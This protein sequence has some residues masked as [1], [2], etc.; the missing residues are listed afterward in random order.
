[1]EVITMFRVK[2]YYK[3]SLCIFVFMCL[4]ASTAYSDIITYTIYER[5]IKKS[6][7][8]IISQLGDK[9]EYLELSADGYVIKNSI[10]PNSNNNISHFKV[11]RSSEEEKQEILKAWGQHSSM[12]TVERRF[13]PALQLV[14][15][16]TRYPLPE[17]VTYVMGKPD[18]KMIP[19][20][21]A[22]EDSESAIRVDFAEIQS[23]EFINPAYAARIIWKN[24]ESAEGTLLSGF[25]YGSRKGASPV[26][27][28]MD[29]ETFAFVELK[30]Q[31]VSKLNNTGINIVKCSG[32]PQHSF[33]KPPLNWK[34]CPVCG[35]PLLLNKS[36]Q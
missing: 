8:I 16:G 33:I 24:G 18:E 25:K 30:L 12:V 36:G 28:G 4:I 29:T 17:N 31:S 32:T 14:G 1:M 15:C 35:K 5:T 9:V 23:V 34:Y 10:D 27:F 13:G 22:G 20:F 11:I 3:K 7:V 6:D 2:E 21:Y 26:L 19:G